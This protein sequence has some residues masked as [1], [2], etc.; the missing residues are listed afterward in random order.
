MRQFTM[1]TMREIWD[2]KNGEH[3]EVGPDRD[4]LDMIE[5]RSRDTD[6]KIDARIVFPL[7]AAVMVAQAILACH[8][9]LKP[10]E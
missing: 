6:N 10:R 9:E 3:F 2:D 1:E 8:D 5:I 4:G 7:E